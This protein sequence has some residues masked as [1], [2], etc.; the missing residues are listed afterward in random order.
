MFKATPISPQPMRHATFKI[1]LRVGSPLDVKDVGNDDSKHC[2]STSGG[3]S[4]S[5]DETFPRPRQWVP[6]ERRPK[7]SRKLSVIEEVSKE[8]EEGFE[9]RNQVEDDG[10][11][12]L[13]SLDK[14]P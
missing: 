13:E 14:N 4:L 9:E 3:K 8:V 12:K 6:Y 7:L 10:L 2:A 5:A 1:Q 11:C